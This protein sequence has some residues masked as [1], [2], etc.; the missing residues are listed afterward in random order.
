VDSLR[1]N[2][3]YGLDICE[4]E[5]HLTRALQQLDRLSSSDFIDI[6]VDVAVG[7]TVWTLPP[8]AAITARCSTG[9]VV[10]SSTGSPSRIATRSALGHDSCPNPGVL[11]LPALRARRFG[12]SQ[13]K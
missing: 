3:E 6:D 2:S 11:T 9:V 10:P 7:V 8:S 4:H 13:I 5:R 12:G 1:S